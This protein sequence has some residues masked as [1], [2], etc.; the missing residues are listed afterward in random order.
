MQEMTTLEWEE[1]CEF[2][3][4]IAAVTDNLDRML[5]SHL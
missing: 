1:E 4:D 5:Y 3:L 2:I